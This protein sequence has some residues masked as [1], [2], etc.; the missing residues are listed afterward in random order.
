MYIYIHTY[1]YIY[2]HIYIYIYIHMWI[3]IYICTYIYTCVLVICI[4][5]YG[6]I[7]MCVCLCIY[8]FKYVYICMYIY[9]HVCVF[10]YMCICVR[11]YVNIDLPTYVLIYL[12]IH[13]RMYWFV[14]IPTSTKTIDILSRHLSSFIP[15]L[16]SRNTSVAGR[17]AFQTSSIGWCAWLRGYGFPKLR[18]HWVPKNGTFNREL[19]VKHDQSWLWGCSY[20]FDAP[21]IQGAMCIHVFRTI[22]NQQMIFYVF[23]F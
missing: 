4:C 18:I 12:C 7:Y 15:A 5:V 3:Y 17:K 2:I 13:L 14:Y 1:I 10:V 9:I 8:V 6:Y 22:G 20:F 16:V 19:M 11:V 23:N 21:K